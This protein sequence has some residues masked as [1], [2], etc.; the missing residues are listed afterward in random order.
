M[1]SP[2]ATSDTLRPQRHRGKALEISPELARARLT[3]V[4]RA[5]LGALVA[6][7]SLDAIVV[8]RD[9]AEIA[10]AL[11]REAGLLPARSAARRGGRAL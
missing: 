6:E 4:A 8:L 7:R 5:P 3:A 10:E 9:P 11:A 2:R 1:D